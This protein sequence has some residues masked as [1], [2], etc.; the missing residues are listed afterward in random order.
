MNFSTLSKKLPP[1]FAEYFIE[2]WEVVFHLEILHA[3]RAKFK[4][5]RGA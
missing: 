4:A 3:V 1:Q 2:N 5:V